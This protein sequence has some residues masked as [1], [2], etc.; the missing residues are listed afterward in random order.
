MIEDAQFCSLVH[1]PVAF[2]TIFCLI[3]VRVVMEQI[4]SLSLLLLI[5]DYAILAILCLGF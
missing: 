5:Q 1:R 3:S 2:L 4:F